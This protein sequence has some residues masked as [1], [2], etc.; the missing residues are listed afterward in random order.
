[1]RIARFKEKIMEVM[2]PKTHWEVEC[3]DVAGDLQWVEFYENLVTDAG[4]NDLLTQYFK[5][6][7]YTAA[8]YIGLINNPA[9]LSAADTS[10]S[11]AGWTEN[12]NFDGASRPT[13]VLGPTGN[14]TMNNSASKAIFTINGSGGTISGTFLCTNPQKGATT[15]ILYSE[16]AFASG[17]KTLV[18]GDVLTVTVTI[19]AS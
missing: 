9:T 4:I 13:L 8:W 1:L 7:G 16:A 14:K 18:A 11:H 3:R 12:T 2:V 10:A 6:G 19:S 15:G 5:G 17:N